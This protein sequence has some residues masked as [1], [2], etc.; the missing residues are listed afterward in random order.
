MS[1][2]R[3][4]MLVD[5]TVFVNNELGEVRFLLGEVSLTHHYDTMLRQRCHLEPDLMG[6]PLRRWQLGHQVSGIQLGFINDD[7]VT[8]CYL[9][10]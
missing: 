7:T 5:D 10:T 4:V 9:G 1:C 2:L 6:A 8:F 3:V